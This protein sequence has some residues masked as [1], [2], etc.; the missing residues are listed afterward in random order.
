MREVDFDDMRSHVENNTYLPEFQEVQKRARRVKRR[1]RLRTLIAIAAVAVPAVAISNAF[2]R[3]TPS[4]NTV[5]ITGDGSVV[6]LSLPTDRAAADT[7]TLVAAD[8]VDLQHMFGLVDVCSGSSCEMEISSID[9][10]GILGTT[11]RIDLFRSHSTDLVS[12][13]RVVAVDADTVIVSAR[14][15]GGPAQAQTLALTAMP[16]KPSP[17]AQLRAVQPGETGDIQL[18]DSGG[19][20]HPLPS[21]PPLTAP[22]LATTASGWWVAGTDPNNS[23]PTLAVSRDEGRNWSVRPM[24][25]SQI[26]SSPAIVQQGNAIYLLASSN[27]KMTLQKSTDDGQTWNPLGGA[28]NW[29]Q[30]SHYGLATAHD[31]SLIAWITTNSGT[32]LLRSGDAGATF[33]P[34]RNPGASAGPIVAVSGGYLMLGGKPA[35]SHDGVTWATATI[36]WLPMR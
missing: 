23:A 30:S 29:P 13:P 24:G 31:K 36:P 10:G 26:D 11:Q 8:G 9:P 25:L 5:A 33:V 32:V 7:W 19:A 15:N 2:Y 21:Q 3:A 20:F 1:H 4:G 35:L 16:M 27:R 18:V 17:A 28:A 22:H 14:V 6:H 34:Y 12:D